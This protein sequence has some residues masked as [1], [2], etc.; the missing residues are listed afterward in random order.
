[1][2]EISNYLLGRALIPNEAELKAYITREA[3]SMFRLCLA[4]SDQA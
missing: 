3:I 2:G 4:S 1:V